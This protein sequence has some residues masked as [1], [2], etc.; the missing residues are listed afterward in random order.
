MFHATLTLKKRINFTIWNVN[1]II[2]Y[3]WKIIGHLYSDVGNLLLSPS[4]TLYPL[5][6]AVCVVVHVLSFKNSLLKYNSLIKIQKWKVNRV[7]TIQSDFV[8][9]NIGSFVFLLQNVPAASMYW[10]G[11]SLEISLSR[12]V[13]NQL[14]R[15]SSSLRIWI[16]LTKMGSHSF[17]DFIINI[18]K[19]FL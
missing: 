13:H 16:T 8:P 15:S 18:F 4:C 12:S 6:C 19:Y 10:I 1:N 11:W 7:S 9:A 3:S 2:V 17:G 14:N 5:N